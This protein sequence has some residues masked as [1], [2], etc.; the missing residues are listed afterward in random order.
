MLHEQAKELTRVNQLA[1]ERIKNAG[2]SLPKCTV[3][4]ALSGHSSEG[5]RLTQSRPPYGRSERRKG[6]EHCKDR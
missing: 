3:V 5:G 4:W 2:F 1:V 6:R